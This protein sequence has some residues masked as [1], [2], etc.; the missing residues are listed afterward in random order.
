MAPDWTLPTLDGSTLSFA[1]LRGNPSV[2]FVWV[3]CPEPCTA[4]WGTDGGMGNLPDV[5]A[6]ADTYGELNVVAVSYDSQEAEVKDV[7]S[8]Q[9]V[10]V[11]V[12]VDLADIGGLEWAWNLHDRPL[13]ILVD[14]EGRAVETL[15]VTATFDEIDAAVR[16]L[17]R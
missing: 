13:W 6:L 8:G 17:L 14:G 15:Q 16:A 12:A 9:N 2:V 11:Q 5:Q 3:V 1:D 7:I 10:T 4:G